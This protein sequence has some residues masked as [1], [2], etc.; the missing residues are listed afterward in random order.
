MALPGL[1]AEL[2][3]RLSSLSLSL[4]WF[5]PNITS[6]FSI[7]ESISS[8]LDFLAFLCFLVVGICRKSEFKN[9]NSVV[10]GKQYLWVWTEKRSWLN[11]MVEEQ[12]KLCL[13][14]ENNYYLYC[15]GRDI[16]N[17]TIQK[18]INNIPKAPDWVTRRASK[19]CWNVIGQIIWPFKF[20]S[21]IWQQILQSGKVH[22]TNVI[23][24]I[25]WEWNC[26]VLARACECEQI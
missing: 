1:L 10:F 20:L 18:C 26:S 9:F 7:S 6:K 16:H 5:S 14:K 12:N 21:S 8:P 15:L 11:W 13:R 23:S 3:S 22:Q 17:T 19:R 24:Q 2:L 4:K 25:F